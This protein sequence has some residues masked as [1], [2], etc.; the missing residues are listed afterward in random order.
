MWHVGNP[1]GR[2]PCGRVHEGQDIRVS[3]YRNCEM[4]LALT[5]G[6]HMDVDGNQ[7]TSFQVFRDGVRSLAG[8]S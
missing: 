4:R 5:I 7:S 8:I 2:R 1:R 3:W 6:P